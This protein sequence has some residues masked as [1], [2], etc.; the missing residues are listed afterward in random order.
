MGIGSGKEL[1]ELANGVDEKYGIMGYGE[2]KWVLGM[3]LECDRVAHTILLLQEAFI[4]SV[5]THFQLTNA[6]PVSTLFPPNIQLSAADCPTSKDEVREMKTYPY[7]ELVS[8]LVWL[9]LGTWPD[10]AFTASSLACFS[11][12][13][14]CTHWEAAKRML[15]YLK[16][17]KNQCLTLGRSALALAIYTDANWGSHRDNRRLVG[18]YLVKIGDRV[19]SWKLK[20]QTCI[21]LLLTKAEY[22][23]L[24][25][26]SKESVWM[27]DFLGSLGVSLQGPVVINANNQ[28][29]IALMRNLVFHDQLKHIDIQYHFA[30]NLIRAGQISLN[31]VP[32]AKMLAD[33]LTKSLPHAHH[34]CLSK[35]IG[36]S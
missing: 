31:Y 18:A 22:M 36:L 33:L 24:C 21:A 17:T 34:L 2:V 29:S 26:A 15:C 8:A 13:P 9:V 7:K 30:C 14:G 3:L 12:N 28:G 20:K 5:L 25:Q 35:A 1:R 27:A 23:A 6:T 10:I 19:V 11:H 32:T 16:G 4:D